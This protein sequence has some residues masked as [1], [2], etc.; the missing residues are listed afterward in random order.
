MDGTQVTYLKRESIDS[1]CKYHDY[2]A[3]M[4]LHRHDGGLEGPVMNNH[5]R[6]LMQ[7]QDDEHRGSSERLQVNLSQ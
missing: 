1:K 5:S 2:S 6:V 4:I 7:R 3:K